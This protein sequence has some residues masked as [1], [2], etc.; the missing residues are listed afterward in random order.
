MGLFKMFGVGGGKLDVV[1]DVEQVSAG[2]AIS[3]AAKFFGGKRDQTIDALTLSLKCTTYRIEQTANG[4]V[5]RSDV[6][7]IVP[8]TIIA[9]NVLSSAGGTVE[10]RFSFPL[11]A[12]LY[13]SEP[14]KVEYKLY[15]AADI[16]GEVDPG[17]S[18][19]I[20]VVGGQA[21]DSV[22]QGVAGPVITG[23]VIGVINVN[24]TVMAQ[25]TDGRWYEGKV[26]N[27]VDDNV[28]VDW[29]DPNLGQSSWVTRALVKSMA[30]WNADQASVVQ[31]KAQAKEEA[32]AA[33]LAAKTAADN[34]AAQKA[35]AQ[36]A[37]SKQALAAQQAAAA[38]AQKAAQAKVAPQKGGP[39]KVVPFGAGQPA[40]KPQVV[41]FGKGQVAAKQAP[42]AAKAAPA[43]VKSAAD[44]AQNMHASAAL[45]VGAKIVAIWTDG[46]W[47][48]GTVS[49]IQPPWIGIDWQD[50]K[51]G[52]SSWV[53]PH[54]V[55]LQ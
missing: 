17:D 15:G 26:T 5:K 24:D 13:N 48:P 40:A 23:S 27:L 19:T 7:S 36:A 42:A 2:G 16:D 20:T 46:N 49:A 55:K 12:G 1:L 3:G 18:E 54:K 11:H 22:A 35:A 34:A 39:Q 29:T 8:K 47:Y 21:F 28:G 10:F 33:A 31:A 37:A 30:T 45:T 6:T 43:P 41:P 38:A 51:L 53:E 44:T 52:A 25:W 50:P 14:G 4:P 9:S 32:K